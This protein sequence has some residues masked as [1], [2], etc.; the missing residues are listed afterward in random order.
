MF[1]EVK[2]NA[3]ACRAKGFEVI[4][5]MEMEIFLE[6]FFVTQTQVWS[7][8]EKSKENKACA[9]MLNLNFNLYQYTLCCRQLVGLTAEISF[10]FC[11]AVVAL[12]NRM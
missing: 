4:V 3:G 5:Q 1:T 11:F 2:V 6:D 9:Q 8:R 12:T 10:V 7:V